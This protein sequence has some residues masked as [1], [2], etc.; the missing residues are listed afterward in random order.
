V[1]TGNF[2]ADELESAGADVVLE[3]FSDAAMAREL[4]LAG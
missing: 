3:D 2:T 4:L 1:A